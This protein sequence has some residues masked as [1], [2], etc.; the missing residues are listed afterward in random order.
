MDMIEGLELYKVPY[1]QEPETILNTILNNVKRAYQKAGIIH[2]DL[3]EFNIILKPDFNVMI[4][5]WP[6]FV[7][8]D[9]P[10]AKMLLERDVKNILVAFRRRFKIKRC[11]QDTLKS[12]ISNG[13]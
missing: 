7:R 6:Q 12:I 1:L 11:L 2:S 9:H 13:V 10:N 3:S 4:I 8:S 5:D